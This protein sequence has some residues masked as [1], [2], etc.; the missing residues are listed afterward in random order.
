MRSRLTDRL[1]GVRNRQDTA[2]GR[3]DRISLSS[4]LYAYTCTRQLHPGVVQQAQ[5][6]Q[7]REPWQLGRCAMGGQHTRGGS[8]THGQSDAGRSSGRFHGNR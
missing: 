5:H 1:K 6:L 4:P 8:L 3:W 2:A 7:T